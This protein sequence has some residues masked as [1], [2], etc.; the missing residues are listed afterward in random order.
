M[1]EL[2]QQPPVKARMQSQPFGNRQH[3]LPVRDWI[4][5]FL[6]HVQR[7]QQSA[8]LMARGTGTALLA[9]VGNEHLVMAVG[10]ADARKTFR[11][12][13]T[14]RKSGQAVVDDGSP[15]TVLSLKTLVIHLPEGGKMLIDQS[16]Q[17]GGLGIA[18]AVQFQRLV[19]G[20]CRFPHD[21]YH[22]LDDEQQ[23]PG[24]QRTGWICKP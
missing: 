7:G 22:C 19:A 3:D 5:D 20:K 16:P 14:S 4:G 10:T 12:I 2:S 11:Q 9:R 18:W 15:E 1:S 13:P 21:W 23:R 8:F 24:H 6:R 17:V